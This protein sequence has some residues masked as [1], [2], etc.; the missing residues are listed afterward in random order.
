MKEIKMNYNEFEIIRTSENLVEIPAQRK[1]KV[2]GRIYTDESMMQRLLSEGGPINQVINVAQLP[3]IQKYSLAMPDIH[4]GYGFPIGGVAATDW[5][6]GVISPGGVGYDINCGVRLAATGLHTK[7]I[8]NRIPSLIKELFRAV[9][10]GVGSSNAIRKLKQKELKSLVEKGVSWIIEQGF[11]APDDLNYIEENGCMHSADADVVSSRAFERGLAQ[12]GTLGSGNHF[13]EI[14]RVDKIY[15]QQAAEA[16][17]LFEDQIVLQIHTGSR[18]FGYQI[19]DDYLKVMGKAVQKYQLD[20]P[21][22]QLAAAPIQSPEGQ[23]YLSAMACAANYAWSNRQVIMH[24]AHKVLRRVL[25]ISESDL[26][27][28]LVYDVSHNIAKKEEHD[29]DGSK[30]TVCVHRK[31]ATRAF[32]SGNDELPDRYISAGQPVLI[33]GDMGRYSFV[34]AGT[35]TAMDET[36]G[37]SCHGA[38]RLM[39]RQKAKKAGRGRDLF[40][41]LNNRGIV[42]QSKGRATIA[43]EMPDAYKNVSHVVDIMHNSGVIKKAARLKPLGVIKG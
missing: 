8:D 42:V 25:K 16:M 43:E 21:D 35:D 9:P 1:M 7:D 34:C 27:F 2:P 28:R 23:N 22:R 32:N 13:L 37:S 40:K 30:K 19:C 5:Q 38:G 41:E 26:Q 14:D 15:E 39:S 36:F 20:L 18:G 24:L 3:G 6:D 33:P 10:T 17:G 12:M 11:G 29:I 31:G 4:W